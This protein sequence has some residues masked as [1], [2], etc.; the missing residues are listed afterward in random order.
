[1]TV[2]KKTTSQINAIQT[3][4]CDYDTITIVDVV[5]RVLIVRATIASV[6]TIASIGVRG[7]IT[8]IKTW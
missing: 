7:K 2:E 1:M 4:Y 5:E 8:I 3:L 6:T